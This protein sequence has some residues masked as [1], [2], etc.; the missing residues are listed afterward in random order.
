MPDRI[1]IFIH[2]AHGALT[3]IMLLKKGRG[4]HPAPQTALVTTYLTI[5]WSRTP[6]FISSSGPHKYV[7]DFVRCHIVVSYIIAH[8]VRVP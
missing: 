4:T 5:T 6:S 3:I 7:Y 8:I 2:L 1:I